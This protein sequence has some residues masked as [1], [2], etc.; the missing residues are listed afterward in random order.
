[1]MC[2]GV[3][4]DRSLVHC[5]SLCYCELLHE[6]VIKLKN[7]MRALFEHCSIWAG[8]LT[9]IIRDGYFRCVILVPPSCYC[10]AHPR[11]KSFIDFIKSNFIELHLT[12]SPSR[13]VSKCY[14][15][16]NCPLFI[17][18]LVHRRPRLLTSF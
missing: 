6:F 9:M 17:A 1:M 16:F 7:V 13:R 5:A 12:L 18:G 10:C 8:D 14:T 4:I 11:N 2:P 3:I 15:I